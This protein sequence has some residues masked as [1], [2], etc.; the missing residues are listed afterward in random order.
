MKGTLVTRS[1][2]IAFCLSIA[3]AWD[4]LSAADEQDL[5]VDFNR[6]VRPIL[7]NHCF[8]C[9][10]P[11]ED[12]READVRLDIRSG[13]IASL[14]GGTAIVPGRAVDSELIDRVNSTD[15]DLRMPP[16]EHGEPLSESQISLLSRWIDQGAAYDKHW[17][18]Q[19]LARPEVPHVSGRASQSQ[20]A[21]PVDAFIHRGLAAVG[22]EP[23]GSASRTTLIR[24]VSLDLL[25]LPPTI[26]QLEAFEN[27]RDPGAYDRMVDRMLASE[28]FGERWGRHWLD[29]ARYADSH[30][31]TND[32]ARSIW[33][34]RDWVI[35]AMNRDLPFDQ[36]TIE[37]L[38][39]DLL[40][41]P[42]L[43]QRVATGFHRNTLINSEGGTKAD[44]FR[45]E[46][47]KDRIDTTGLVWM[48]LTVG[49]A[50]CHA[51]KF[52][53]LSQAEYYGLYAYFNS[54]ADRN[55]V[56]PTVKVPSAQQSQ[57][58]Q[59][60]L[61]QKAELTRQI[62]DDEQR[63]GRQTAWESQILAMR[64]RVADDQQ[65]IPWTVLELSGK[66]NKQSTFQALPDR[67]LLVHGKGT[68]EEEYQ[69]TA[70]SPLTKV[71]SVRLQVLVDESLPSRGPGRAG[72]GNF[73]LSE[74][75][76]RTGDG[77]ELR[78]A[79]AAAE[80]SQPKFEIAKS[81]DGKG[82]TGWAINGAPD[83]P[84]NRNRT[85]WFV[86]PE[87]LEIEEDH[88]LV[89]KMQ[90]HV[91]ENYGIG[92][93]RLSISDQEWVD[94]PSADAIA[95]LLAVDKPQR[96]DE[97]QA[98]IDKAF[99]QSDSQLSKI[100][101]RRDEITATIESIQRSIP[102]T[103]V[104]Q[105]LEQPRQAYVQIRGDF[106]RRG[107]DVIPGVPQALPAVPPTARPDRLTL[108]RWLTRADHPL[109][110]RVRVNR[111][112]MRLFGRGLVETENDFGIQGTLPT[113]PEL[114]D[115][116]AWEFARGG[117]STK[118]LLRLIMTSATYRQSSRV[119]PELDSV[120][121]RNLLLARQSRLRVEA[122]I[123]RDL[124]LTVSGA[125]SDKLGGPSVF[126][127]Q[128]DGVYAFTQRSKQ[129]KTS[130]GEDRYRRGMYTFFYRSAPYPMLTTFDV[131][132]FNTVCTRRD[133]S[134]TPLQSL[135]MANSES[136]LE[137]G[138]QLGDR[139]QIE[140]AA[141]SDGDRV[142]HGYRLCFARWPS[143]PEVERME[144]YVKQCRERFGDETKVWAAVA[145]VMM[146]LDEFVTRE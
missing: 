110:A 125:L 96:R 25:G 108:A 21:N 58:L 143:S 14:G 56:T 102:S 15:D 16:A 114:L 55:S 77:R 131:P 63:P 50:K 65:T 19:P 30:G 5:A 78:F 71:R 95:Q 27:D 119:R 141:D 32:N 34:Y 120:D 116:L 44:Q 134:N 105:E 142:R 103:M 46:Q 98:R 42:T 126:P 109:T 39:G 51:H 86:L 6:D 89:F 41:A 67:S 60:L 135:T 84:P 93:Y 36:F 4:P 106:L 3:L 112:W 23:S 115:W 1:P 81:I 49:C 94:R 31:Y 75:W 97:Q 100:D 107:E 136:L 9:H 33:P 38:A 113:H 83:G 79:K 8:Q 10:G 132:K 76:F 128:P 88:A 59:D 64:D 53:P 123:V 140:S 73:V 82:D 28:R 18:F 101:A 99:L 90:F 145:R 62:D 70:R 2:V 43:E 111:I 121:P 124:A 20:K 104:L 146:N 37:Q 122:E 61:V 22:V 137:L 138:A 35:N 7:S 69:S 48:G 87:T 54:T 29:Q 129:W 130:Q 139:I 85:A 40:A 118:R 127:P 11:D 68:R 57:A 72:N 92:R 12:Q 80:H 66:S 91:N 26:K 133:R 144:R 52:D 13:G 17:S 24:R 74:F 47:V 45:D 117:W